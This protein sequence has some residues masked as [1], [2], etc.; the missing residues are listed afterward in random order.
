MLDTEERINRER[1]RCVALQE[2]SKGVGKRQREGRG[3]RVQTVACKG[4]KE[5]EGWKED[6]MFLRRDNNGG[7][8]G[9][10]RWVCFLD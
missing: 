6:T 10:R 8:V 4:R 5:E 1:R 7:Q 3:E 9:Q 2:C